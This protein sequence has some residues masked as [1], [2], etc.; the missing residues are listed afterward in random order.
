MKRTVFSFTAAALLATTA[1]ADLISEFEPNPAGTDPST[2]SVELSGTPF[3]AFSGFLTFI[4]TDSGQEGA[5]NSSDAVSGNYDAKGLAV[6]TLLFDVENPSYHLFFSS[7]QPGGDVDA[8]NDG[9]LDDAVTAFGTIYDS[10]GVIDTSGDAVTYGP[11]FVTGTEWEIA[12]R[13]ASTGAWYGVDTGAS[14]V[15]DIAGNLL[16]DAL[17]VGDPF[18]SS[19]NAINPTFV[20][21]PTSLALLGLGGLLIARRRRG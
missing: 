10:I 4:D 16:N 19:Y 1:S 20:P 3:A 21:E 8:D 14:E 11:E 17:F 6:I 12:F 18:S 13:D 9:V 2:S 7:L 15:Y 5:I